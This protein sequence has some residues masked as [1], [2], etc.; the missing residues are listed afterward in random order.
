MTDLKHLNERMKKHDVTVKYTNN[1]FN[2]AVLGKTNILFM[3]DSVY[4]RRIGT[5]LLI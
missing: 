3:L 2:L 4:R 1:T 5:S